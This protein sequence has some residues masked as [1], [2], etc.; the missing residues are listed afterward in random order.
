MFQEAPARADAGTLAWNRSGLRGQGY[1]RFPVL[2][3]GNSASARLSS[4]PRVQIAEGGPEANFRIRELWWICAERSRG[5]SVYGASLDGLQIRFGRCK[6]I[7]GLSLQGGPKQ[8]D[9]EQ[10]TAE[11]GSDIFASSS[12]Y[13]H[14]VQNRLIVVR[15]S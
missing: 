1:R 7:S 4:V 8:E 14:H 3:D 15:E 6:I 5:R 9:Q 13:V 11:E 10:G 12:A 2:T